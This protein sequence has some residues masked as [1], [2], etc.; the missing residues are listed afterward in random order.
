MSTWSATHETQQLPPRS[1]WIRLGG[2]SA[3]LSVVL[4]SVAFVLNGRTF[5]AGLPAAADFYSALLSG[6]PAGY[7]AV[8]GTASFLLAA[9]G[10]YFQLRLRDPLVW[11]ALTAVLLGAVFQ[12]AG[13]FALRYAFM[14]LDPRLPLAGENMRA[15]LF[16]LESTL[17]TTADILLFLGSAFTFGFGVGLFGYFQLR[18]GLPSAR[19]GWMGLLAGVLH[20]GWLDGL[21]PEP[22]AAFL[23]WIKILD[24]AVYLV[25]LALTGLGL[26]RPRL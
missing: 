15:Y 5:A 8:A 3:L 10:L 25:W 14:Q 20:I 7:L 22:L 26:L 1:A 2:F 23:G 21:A 6:S 13:F 16:A 12:L 19:L 4:T 24:L 11:A 9:L 18:S 17:L